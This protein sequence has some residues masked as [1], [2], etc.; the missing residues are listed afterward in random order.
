VTESEALSGRHLALRRVIVP[1]AH[2]AAKAGTEV[3]D[4]ASIK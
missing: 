3:A 1:E 4:Q 2:Y